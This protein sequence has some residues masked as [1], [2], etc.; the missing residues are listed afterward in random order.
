MKLEVGGG[1]QR[2]ASTNNTDASA[3]AQS[4]VHTPRM[5]RTHQRRFVDGGGPEVV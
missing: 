3:L 5:I 1:T 2:N 4:P